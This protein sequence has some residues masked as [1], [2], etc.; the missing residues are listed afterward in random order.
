MRLGL[1]A[2]LVFSGDRLFARAFERAIAGSRFRFSL[3]QRGGQSAGIV[4]LGDSRAVN[5]FYAPEISRQLGEPVLNLGYNGMSTRIEEAVFHDY[6]ARSFAPRL[7]VLEVTN[8]EDEHLL[9]DDLSCYWDSCFALGRLAEELRPGHWRATHI[10]HLYAF[11]GE[12][13][14]RALYYARRS[15]QDWINRYRIGPELLATARSQPAFELTTRRDN[16]EALNRMVQLAR[17]RGIVVRLVVTPYL[18][19]YIGHATNGDSWLATIRRAAGP[20]MRVWDYR[21]ADRDP[22]HF[23]DRVHLNDLGSPSFTRLL[24]RDGFFDTDSSGH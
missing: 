6:L 2:L 3:I 9:L 12:V 8:V 17:D 19:D 20:G 14:I 10:S 13:P 23:A 4:V 11:D 21:L 16:L 18:P 24:I 7:L 5:G 22:T 1:L 15:D